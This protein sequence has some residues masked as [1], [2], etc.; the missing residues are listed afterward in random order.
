M[1]AMNKEKV[2]EFCDDF[3]CPFIVLYGLE[4]SFVGIVEFWNGH[5][6]SC[7]DKDLLWKCLY[8]AG[9]PP[10]VVDEKLENFYTFWK[11]VQE[12]DEVFKGKEEDFIKFHLPLL[13]TMIKDGASPLLK[14]IVWEENEEK[15]DLKEIIEANERNYRVAESTN[16][17]II[18]DV[19]KVLDGFE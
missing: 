1:K 16:R 2:K 9:L 12:N 15:N 17:N 13:I 18:E 5:K 8:D 7:Y 10:D 11:E 6:V 3:N 14:D 4:K 19:R